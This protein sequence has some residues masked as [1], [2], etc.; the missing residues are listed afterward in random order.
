MIKAAQSI[1]N[2]MRKLVFIETG[3]NIPEIVIKTNGN[4]QHALGL[5]EHNIIVE[6]DKQWVEYR[7]TLNTRAFKGKESSKVFRKIV[8]HEFCHIADVVVNG[9]MKGHGRGWSQLMRMCGERAEALVSKEDTDELGYSVYRYFHACGCKTHGVSLKTHR[10]IVSGTQ[11]HCNVC[12]TDIS[13]TF[14]F[15]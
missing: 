11:H 9:F 1:V 14:K 10:A 5:A 8:I 7:I 15:L 6:G 4:L 3:V 12:Y 13:P 2:E